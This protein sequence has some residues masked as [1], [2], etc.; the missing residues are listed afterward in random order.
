MNELLVAKNISKTYT[1][2][3][4]EGIKVLKDVSFS[5]NEKNVSTIVGASGAGKSTLLHILSALDTPDKGEVT[6]NGNNLLTLSDAKASSF[7]NKHIGFIFQFHHLLPEF[8][9]IENVAIPQMISGVS[10]K[11]AL[12]KAS[13]ILEF[14]EMAHRADHKPAELSGG[15]QQRIAVAR[16]LINNPIIIFAD[17]PTGNLDSANSRKLQNLFVNLNKEFNTAF[18]IVTHNKELSELGE[19]KWEM[20]DGYLKQ[21]H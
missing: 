4:G 17:E 12:K 13:I 10:L 8:S 20:E 3:K 19:K 6:I 14:V 16:S 11:K 21:L 18:L 9:A 7:R 1:N 5:I 15:E 2:L